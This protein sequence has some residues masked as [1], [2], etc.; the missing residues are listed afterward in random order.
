MPARLDEVGSHRGSTARQRSGE[1]D[2]AK[3]QAKSRHRLDLRLFWPYSTS[4]V[5][6]GVTFLSFFLVTRAVHVD[7]CAAR[8]ETR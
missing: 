5:C 1:N 8:K 2:A 4:A 6:L 7:A 3:L